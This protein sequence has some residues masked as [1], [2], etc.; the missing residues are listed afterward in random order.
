MKKRTFTTEEALAKKVSTLGRACSDTIEYDEK[1]DTRLEWLR[2]E[3]PGKGLRI[4]IYPR[5]DGVSASYVIGVL[6]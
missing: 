4:K 6:A 5:K 2:A 1:R 3:K